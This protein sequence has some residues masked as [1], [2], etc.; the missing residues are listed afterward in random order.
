MVMLISRIPVDSY[1]YESTGILE[2]NIPVKQPWTRSVNE[3][4]ITHLLTLFRVASLV[5]WQLYVCP[6]A[7]ET[8]QKDVGEL[9]CTKPQQNVWAM[10]EVCVFNSQTIQPCPEWHETMTLPTDFYKPI[11][12]YVLELLP[13]SF[14][15]GWLDSILS[16]H[17]CVDKICVYAVALS[18]KIMH[19]S[20][21]TF[22]D[23]LFVDAAHLL[24]RQQRW[25][26]I[27]WGSELLPCC[28]HTKIHCRT[29]PGVEERKYTE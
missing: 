26:L 13:S 19:K 20:A 17:Q 15:G 5:V 29:W 3:L 11:N 22:A 21:V 1:L 14:S 9:T 25:Y 2:I 16:W 6:T 7:I 28:Q 23:L 10:Y 12:R 8:T 4:Y 27:M 24:P 18:M